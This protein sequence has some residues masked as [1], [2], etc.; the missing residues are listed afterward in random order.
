MAAWEEA[1]RTDLQLEPRSSGSDGEVGVY[2]D[3]F[4][5]LFDGVVILLEGGGALQ[6]A[7]RCQIHFEFSFFVS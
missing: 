7:H 2:R 5:G 3:Q 4:N 6:R 1:M